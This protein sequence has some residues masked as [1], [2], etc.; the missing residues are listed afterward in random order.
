LLKSQPKF[1]DEEG[2]K[3]IKP[4][5]IKKLKFIDKENTKT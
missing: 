3:H 2:E 4:K 1:I 5:T